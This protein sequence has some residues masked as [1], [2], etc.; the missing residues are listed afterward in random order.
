MKKYLMLILC[1]TYLNAQAQDCTCTDSFQD[2]I[3]NVE[4]NYSLFQYKVSKKMNNEHLYAALKKGLSQKAQT[5]VNR[6]DCAKLLK[7]YI[8][9][10]NDGHLR[11]TMITDEK[12]ATP[13]PT[14]ET[15]RVDTLAVLKKIKKQKKPNEMLGIWEADGYRMLVIEENNQSKKRDYV[16]I[17]L[18]SKNAAWTFGKVKME[19][20]QTAPQE[21]DTKYYMGNFSLKPT[22]THTKED[23]VL[24]IDGLSKWRKVFPLPKGTKPI[25]WDKLKNELGFR[26]LSNQN[27]YIKIPSFNG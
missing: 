25:A 12:E 21:Y 10:F 2:L 22:Q 5:T 27:Y 17:I 11:L 20:T 26:D 13:I 6:A 8:S 7:T 15:V 24:N 16:G 23:Y 3:S 18:S 4:E 9:F 14:T 19:F 1:L